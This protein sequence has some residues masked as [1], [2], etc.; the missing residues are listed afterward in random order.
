MA[1]G[2]RELRAVFVSHNDQDIG[3]PGGAFTHGLPPATRML[4]Q[5]T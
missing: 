1:I 4:A 5:E 3:P 2:A